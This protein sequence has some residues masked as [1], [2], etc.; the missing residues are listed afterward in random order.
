MGE[1][2]PETTEWKPFTY[3]NYWKFREWMSDE[4]I[5]SFVRELH[6]HGIGTYAYLS[7]NE[8]GGR[9][10]D[11]GTSSASDDILDGPLAGALVLDP[12]GKVIRTWESA[13]VVNPGRNST[14]WPYLQ[15]QVRRHLVRLPEVDGFVVD[16][17]DWGCVEDWSRDDGL[18]MYA[19]RS[20]QS[21]VRP[22][23]DVLTEIARQAHGAG[24]R[25]FANVPYRIELLKNLD[26]ICTEDYF[27]GLGYLS[28]LR[29]ISAWEMLVYYGD[30]APLEAQLKQRL[31]FAIF[32][33][34]IAHQFIIS[35][36]GPAPKAADLLEI[37]APLFSALMATEQVLEP[38]C[39]FVTGPNDV[40]LLR[41]MSGQYV[42]PISSRVQFL[43]RPHQQ[44]VPVLVA[45]HTADAAQ[46][47]WAHAFSAD[48][49][50]YRA[51]VRSGSRWSIV[52][53]PRHVTATALVMGK[54][55]EPLLDDASPLDSVRER[56]VPPAAPGAQPD[57]ARP[58]L[59]GV[60]NV[61]VHLTGFQAG[62]PG[63]VAV[64][65]DGLRLAQIAGGKS[66]ALFG[67][68]RTE[69]PLNL[70]QITLTTGDQGTWFVPE[71][72]SL[73]TDSD[74]G[75]RCRV[76]EWLQGTFD[77]SSTAASLQ[78]RLA[79]SSPECF[80]LGFAQFDGKD[81]NSFGQWRGRIGTK[82]VWIP[83]V[84]DTETEQGG[85]QL[86]AGNMQTFLWNGNAEGDNRVLENAVG[87]FRPASCW[88]DADSVNF[89]IAPP[90]NEPYRLTVYL[91]D[92]D[93]AGRAMEV[94]VARFLET[95]DTQPVSREE[96]AG[97]VYLSWQVRG[98]IWLRIKNVEGINAVVSGVFI[99]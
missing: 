73:V 51:V 76:A 36:E 67:T 83:F 40:N 88:F 80:L 89:R 68:M 19:D 52:S 16:R 61:L 2:L 65:V 85:F 28:P 77:P 45:L 5:R 15:E 26:G 18:S 96:T 46:M 70:P 11:T 1:F 35:Q 72:I 4:R 43:S 57:A 66:E 56:L 22:T 23:A 93:R 13:A 7:V 34:M 81:T 41:N 6:E 25:V 98:T 58:M 44:T 24:K 38:H 71:R 27:R 74:S 21:M 31:Q 3:S 87:M 49:P 94:S 63:V 9:D 92:Y 59:S 29:P 60:T 12:D 69:L 54:G 8:W 86:D 42:V 62:A 91:L 48:G 79:W 47:A 39:V 90:D 10:G 55:A 14:L 50:P 99:D 53:L 30:L 17:L 32:P 75:Q 64:F 95:L 97:G 82:A 84:S 78:L 37:Y 33:H 20:F